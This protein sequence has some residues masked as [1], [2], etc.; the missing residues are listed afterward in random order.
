MNEKNLEDMRQRAK[1]VT[2]EEIR[3]DLKLLLKIYRHLRVRT[4]FLVIFY[5]YLLG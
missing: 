2:F 5:L 3:H 4:L 1:R